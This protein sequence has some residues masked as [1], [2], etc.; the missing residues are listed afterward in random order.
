[1][2]KLILL[3]LTSLSLTAMAN[4]DITHFVQIRFT[5]LDTDNNGSLSLTELRGTNR[6]WMTKAGFDE[7]KQIK[8]TEDKM[9]QLDTNQDKQVSIEE[10]SVLHN[11]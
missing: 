10:F 8:K 9:T 5:A 3:A 7:A 6:G 1:M 4:T 2:K 11:K